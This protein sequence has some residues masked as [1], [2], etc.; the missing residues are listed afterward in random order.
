[1]CLSE[2]PPSGRTTSPERGDSVGFGTVVGSVGVMI[3]VR[4][5]L[6]GFFVGT[7]IGFMDI[8]ISGTGVGG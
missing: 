6:V 3:F 1:M 4:G 7:L 5:A 2:G 8:V